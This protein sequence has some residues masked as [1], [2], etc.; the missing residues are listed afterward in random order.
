MIVIVSAIVI[1]ANGVAASRYH[2]GY[3]VL[4]RATFGM[5]GHYFF[6]LIRAIL[7]I[8]W[9]R[10]LSSNLHRTTLLTVYLSD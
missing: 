3:P 4:A 6:V 8:I 5:Y 7:G 2:I 1:V 9:V 10:S